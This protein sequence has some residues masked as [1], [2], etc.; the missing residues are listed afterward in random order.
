MKINNFLELKDFQK[1]IIENEKIELD[2]SLLSRVDKSFQFL[3]EFSKNKVIYGVNTGFGP[4]AQFK[5]SDEDTHQLQYNLI[6]SHSSGIG[7]PLP[8]E[9]VKACML[10]R[11]N[12]LSLGN[13]GVHQSVI[14]LL[15]E[16]I[17]RDITPLIFEHGGVGASGDLVQLAHLALVLIGE[18]EVFYNGE[19]KSTKEVFEVEGLEPIKVEIREGLALMNGTSVMSGIG[20]VN[21]YKANQL[22]DISL[23]LSCAINEIVQ[24]YDD[25][26][27]EALNGTKKHY[28][29]QKVAERMRAHLAD[30]KLI[31]KR[32]EHLYTHFE[33]QEKVFKEKVQEYYSLRCVP[34][35]LG[36]V[37]DT[38]E[39]TEK[40]LENEIN[41][42]N[43]NPII[44]VE[45]QHV[46]HG[47]NFH[48]D[49]IS[50]EMDKLKIVV[51]KLTMLAERQLNYLLN[52]KINEILPPFVN[53]GKLGFNFGM[54]G[55]QFTATS[56]T[57]E[58]Q[59]LSNSMYVHSI[60]NNNDNQDIVS[61]GTNAAV[62]CR[63]VIENAFEVLAIE[64]IT[65]IQAVEYL[66]FQDK[67]SSSTKELYDDIR[68]IIPAFSD[69]MVM[70]PYLEEVKKYLKG[71]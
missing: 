23:R 19:R 9:E 10:A 16:L 42:A 49:Y 11:L 30:S 67:V 54:Q 12:T 25:H 21:A 44:N 1:I 14:Y 65:I 47:G 39:Y 48:G 56:T 13:S 58:S 38:L 59:M 6:R 53:L 24:A 66:G 26:L 64:A 50:L 71:M 62:I 45:D 22:T 33:E 15:Q 60:P 52:A 27:S 28:G 5:I 36:P 37:L 18:G 69:D 32:E 20:I 55:V 68:K 41:S 35:I 61:M 57:A 3:K 34:Q 29:Q 63:K 70:Y 40:V 4:M 8:V 7:N 2:E 31:R 43:D 17:N 51:T 46:Y